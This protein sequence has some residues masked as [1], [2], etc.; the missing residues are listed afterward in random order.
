[1]AAYRYARRSFWLSVA[2]AGGLTGLIVFLTFAATRTLA[3]RW[4]DE[5]TIATGLV[6]FAFCS[7][8][9]ILDY[10]R[11]ETVLAIQP[12][13]YL[14]TRWRDEAVPWNEIRRIEMHRLETQYAIS[15]YLWDRESA[16]SGVASG[17]DGGGLEPDHTS[18]ITALDAPAQTIADDLARY[19]EVTVLN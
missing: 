18:E 17:A 15:I 5:I 13:G 3:L 7:L 14:D 2:I 9:L 4:A 11:A 12:Q 19:T 1:M 8:R 10:A 16:G 6:F